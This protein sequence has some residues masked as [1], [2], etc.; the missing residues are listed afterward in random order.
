MKTGVLVLMKIVI[1]AFTDP[2]KKD[3]YSTK[4]LKHII[5]NAEF[6]ILTSFKLI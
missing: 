3:N 2:V 6:K 4:N 5:E 1:S